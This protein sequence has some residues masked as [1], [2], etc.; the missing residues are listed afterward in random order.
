MSLKLVAACALLCAVV[1]S[2]AAPAMVTL[3]SPTFSVIDFGDA[4]GWGWRSL[5]AAAPTNT[6]TV[7]IAPKR[8]H[9]D[10][11]TRFAA[12]VSNPE[13]AAYTK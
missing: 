7:T 11:L 9:M 6:I 1:A 8:T 5:G 12:D 4:S 2:A 10:E 13:S 3:S